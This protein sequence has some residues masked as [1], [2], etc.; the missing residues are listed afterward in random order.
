[1]D[2]ALREMIEEIFDT[3]DVPKD[4]IATLKRRFPPRIV[5]QQYTYIIATYSFKDLEKMLKVIS[6]FG[7]K[8]PYPRMR[9]YGVFSS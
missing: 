3:V 7:L 5:F 1:M 4:L 9:G 8:S 6:K 2:T